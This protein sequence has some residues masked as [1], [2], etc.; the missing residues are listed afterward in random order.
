MKILGLTNMMIF[1]SGGF[2]NKSLVFFLLRSGIHFKC[3]FE[4]QFGVLL[5][6]KASKAW[7][8]HLTLDYAKQT[9]LPN[10]ALGSRVEQVNVLL[11]YHFMKQFKRSLKGFQG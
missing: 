2:S 3:Y 10:I 6:F 5:N 4:K 8:I 9:I 7:N 11:Y 1:Q